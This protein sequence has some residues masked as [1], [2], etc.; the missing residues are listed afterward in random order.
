MSDRES[1]Q[2]LHASSVLLLVVFCVGVAVGGSGTAAYYNANPVT[3]TQYQTQYQTVE[4]P[5]SDNGTVF[6]IHTGPHAP[7]DWGY[8]VRVEFKHP[9]NDEWED[10]HVV[11]AFEGE[12]FVVPLNGS[13]RYQISVTSPN[14]ET[15]VLGP[16][17][18]MESDG[19]VELVVGRCC[20]DNFDDGGQNGSG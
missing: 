7:A 4:E 18:P 9:V 13:R 5:V 6:S 8:P 10:G 19:S 1:G 12:E 11:S 20:I 3:E 15:R 2:N 14:N 16:F 17:H